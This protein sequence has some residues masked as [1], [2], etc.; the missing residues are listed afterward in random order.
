MVGFFYSVTSLF[1][2]LVLVLGINVSLCASCSCEQQYPR[3]GECV[4]Y[5]VYLRI[6]LSDSKYNSELV[7][8]CLFFCNL[9][10]VIF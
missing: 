10:N 3:P 8:F 2:Y 5:S 6:E 1:V 9:F 4:P 7:F